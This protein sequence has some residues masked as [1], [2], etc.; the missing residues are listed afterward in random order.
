[1]LAIKFWTKWGVGH[2]HWMISYGAMSNLLFWE[3]LDQN[4]VLGPRPLVKLNFT[5]HLD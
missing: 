1:M 2:K 4:I 5:S 3:Q